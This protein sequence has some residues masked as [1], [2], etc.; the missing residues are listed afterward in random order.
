MPAL[1]S[2]HTY[3][4]KVEDYPL[5]R[6]AAVTPD[7]NNDLSFV[8]RA[9]YVGGAGD[10]AIITPDGDSVTLKAVPVGTMLS[11]RVARV[12]STGTSATN[13]VAFW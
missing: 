3:R 6:A 5:N 2:P 7:D 9:V 12:K 1:D 10:V 11:I 8:T 13:L 4:A